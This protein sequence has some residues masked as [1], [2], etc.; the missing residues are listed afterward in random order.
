MQTIMVTGATSGLGRSLVEILSKTDQ[1]ICVGRNQAA[2]NELAALENVIE[3]V[4]CDLGDPKACRALMEGRNVDVLVNNAGVLP[5]RASFVDLPEDAINAM[6]DVNFRSVVHLTQ[7]AVRGMQERG[8]GHVVF[9][10]SSAGR[11]PHPGATVYG[12]SKAAVSL[13]ADALRAE[14]VDRRIRVTEVAPGRI[15]SNLYREAIGNDA[16]G[17][18]YDEY[19]PLEPQDVAEAIAYALRAPRHVDVSRIEIMPIGQAVGGGRTVRK[20]EMK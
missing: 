17:E 6:I 11:F 3:T 18:L 7:A 5:S 13:F 14:L 20:T 2:L 12:A 1:V 9:V 15:R 16:S 19:E 4:A 8:Q 10:G